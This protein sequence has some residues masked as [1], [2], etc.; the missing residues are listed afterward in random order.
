[1][2][3]IFAC[4]YLYTGNLTI[5]TVKSRYSHCLNCLK[6]WTDSTG[7]KMADFGLRAKG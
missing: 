3:N 7:S 2:A 5:S 1:M 4:C 6:T